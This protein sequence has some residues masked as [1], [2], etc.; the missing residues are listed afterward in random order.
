MGK[1]SDLE[2]ICA[3]IRAMKDL[4]EGLERTG[5]GIPAVTRNTARILASIK[6][7]EIN[8]CDLAESDPFA[9]TKRA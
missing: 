2:E 9:R 5:E 1:Q 6:M 8:I 3:T 4:A 7:L